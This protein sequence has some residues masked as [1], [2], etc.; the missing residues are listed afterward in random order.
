MAE[1]LLHPRPACLVAIGGLSGSGKSTIAGAL[2]P[3][4]GAVPGAIVLRSD[5][6]RKRIC[7]VPILTRLG[8]E[9]YTSEITNTVYETLTERAGVTVRG[10]FTAIVDATFLRATDRQAIEALARADA[11]PFIGL[12]LEGPA[13]TLRERLQH[14]EHDASD[15]DTTVLRMQSTQDTGAITW[16]QLDS[17]AAIDVVRE[18]ALSLLRGHLND[19]PVTPTQ[20]AMP[21]PS[22]LRR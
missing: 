3:L 22:G 10:G 1:R 15:A 13:E 12:W 8:P 5:E 4:L 20:S 6:I 18:K 17:S 9:A 7:G 2:A 19:A 14:R 11:V 21:Q 16:H